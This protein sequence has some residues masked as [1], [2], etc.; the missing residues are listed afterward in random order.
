MFKILDEVCKP[1]RATENSAYMDLF[2]RE[3]VVIVAGESK[4]IPLGIKIDLEKLKLNKFKSANEKVHIDSPLWTGFLESHCLEVVMINSLAVKGFIIANGIGIINLDCPD[5]IGLIVHLPMDIQS[6][7]AINENAFTS[8]YTIN[9]GDKVAQCTL[10]EHKGY[11]MGYESD[12]VCE[13][14]FGSAGE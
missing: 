10:K 3:D 2:A 8:E 6:V 1:K 5:E 4:T 9:K 7:Y 14:G 13:G 11:L 12:V